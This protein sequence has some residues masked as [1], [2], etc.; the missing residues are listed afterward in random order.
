[1][2]IDTRTPS[3]NAYHLQSVFEENL[4]SKRGAFLISRTQEKKKDNYPGP[5]AYNNKISWTRQN[6]I[7]MG[8]RHSFFY[9]DNLKGRV[10]VSPQRYRINRE[11]VEKN[12]YHEIG[13]GYGKRGFEYGSFTPGVGSYNLPKMLGLNKFPIN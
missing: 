3:P 8:I 1:M 5:G 12:R 4:K 7:Q 11:S 2:Y 13:I 10:V 6:P 9:E